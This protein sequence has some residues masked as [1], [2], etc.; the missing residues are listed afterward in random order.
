MQAK[1]DKKQTIEVAAALIHERGKYLI[2]QRYPS[3]HLGLMWEFPGGKRKKNESIQDCLRREIK[4][5]L[6]LD[7]S[8]HNLV[9]EYLHPYE[10]RLIRLKFFECQIM[11]GE[12]RVLDCHDFKWQ[13]PKE[14]KI[15]EFPPA[16]KEIILKI[17][18]T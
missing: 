11:R 18:K 7:I 3:S 9:G 1:E 6:G 10:D 14:M 8:V 12:P 2:T 16:D 13:S 15:N 5:E 4:E 17:R